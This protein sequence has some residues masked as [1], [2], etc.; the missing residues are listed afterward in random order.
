MVGFDNF[1]GLGV[2]PVN[3]YVVK[4]YSFPDFLHEV[5]STYRNHP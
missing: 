4:I 1:S 2:I 5:P 3:H